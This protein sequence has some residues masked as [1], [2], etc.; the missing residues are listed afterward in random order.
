L[1][2]WFTDYQL[3]FIWN[4]YCHTPMHLDIDI[5]PLVSA[6]TAAGIP[7][8]PTALLVKAAG[9]LVEEMPLLNRVLL[10]TPWGP[11][12]LELNEIRVNMPV[13]I[14]NNGQPFLSA[15]VIA[16][17]QQ[18]SATDL[19][20]QI[21]AFA[22]GT[23]ADKPIGRFLM[24]GNWFWNRWA[25]QLLHVVAY[26]LPWVYEKKGGGISVSSLVREGTHH[27]RRG[28][29]VGHTSITL[30]LSGIDQDSSGRTWMR[31]GLDGNHS[32]LSGS[33]IA[34]AAKRIAAILTESPP[35]RFYPE[36]AAS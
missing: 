8:A 20:Q 3:Q 35:Q 19:R 24:R 11:R 33:E 27:P 30:L 21:R 5:T 32:I 31:V 34:E 7:L 1:E 16:D 18:R 26:R 4:A 17:P 25:L 29:A 12:I 14:H 2:E 13:R 15:M 9:H 28:I 6:T 10:R 22:Q 23:L 36:L